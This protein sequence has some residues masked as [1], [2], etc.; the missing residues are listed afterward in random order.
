ML[1]G[2]CSGTCVE[3]RTFSIE[4]RTSWARKCKT[5]EAMTDSPRIHP[6]DTAY[7]KYENRG[8]ELK[9][10]SKNM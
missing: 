3:T 6:N 8:K 7:Y 10:G 5:G 2:G 1:G 9:N 4:Q